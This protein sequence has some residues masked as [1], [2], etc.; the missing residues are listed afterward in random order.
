MESLIKSKL[1]IFKYKIGASKCK[2]C[3]FNLQKIFWFL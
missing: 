1:G 3:R 2:S